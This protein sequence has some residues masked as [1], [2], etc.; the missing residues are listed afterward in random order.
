M[1]HVYTGDGKGKTTAAIGLAIRALGWGKK[2]FIVQLLKGWETGEK[3][4]FENLIS[5]GYPLKY[6]CTG[7]EKFLSLEAPSP[8]IVKKVN[9]VLDEAILEIEKMKPDIIVVDEINVAL[10]YDI[11]PMKK[12]FMLIELAEKIGAEIV[13]TGRKAPREII[14]RADLVTEMRKIKH[15]FDKGVFARKGIEF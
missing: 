5:H 9:R 7:P 1:L 8:D 3:R 4:I 2:V 10:A 13:F 6:V 15:Y 14:E 11:V 12:A